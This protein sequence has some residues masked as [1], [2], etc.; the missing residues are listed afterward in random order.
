MN[1][2]SALTTSSS[3][4]PQ[5]VFFIDESAYTRKP[6]LPSRPSALQLTVF[7]F[8]PDMT[9]HPLTQLSSNLFLG[10]AHDAAEHNLLKYRITH[11]INCASEIHL[12][13]TNRSRHIPRWRLNMQDDATERSLERHG[14]TVAEMIRYIFRRNPNAR[15]LIH[16][17]MG[18]SR[19]VSVCVL[20]IHHLSNTR[21]SARE[22][23]QFIQQRRPIANPNSHFR[24]I[25]DSATRK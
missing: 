9:D 17:A 24:S 16:C 4:S 8:P 6:N 19:S 10:N 25:L 20:V 15:I 11:V 21:H 2:S 18:V 14:R 23:L 1:S 3:K 7:T 5:N 13:A 22:I 12:P